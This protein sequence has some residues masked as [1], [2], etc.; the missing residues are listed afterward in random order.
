M[1]TCP[2]CAPCCAASVALGGVTCGALPKY[3]PSL[4]QRISGA[5]SSPKQQYLLLQA[6]SEVVSTAAAPESSLQISAADVSSILQLLLGSS[7]VEEE[8]R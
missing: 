5:A 1:L 7:E 3:L 6:L 8:C 2:R 4:L